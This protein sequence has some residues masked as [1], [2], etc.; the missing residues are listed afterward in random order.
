[1]SEP[2]SVCMV[3]TFYPPH[4]FGGDAMHVYR[5]SNELARRGHDV[6]VVH[7]VAAYRALVGRGPVEGGFPNEP[8]VRVLGI[9]TPLGR[10][11]LLADYL[12]GRPLVG[13]SALRE[14]L[15]RRFDVV[16]FHN[17]S[18]VGGPG[19]LALG[20]RRAVRLYTTNEHWLVC[21]MHVL[22]RMNKEPCTRPTCTRCA[23]AFRRPPQPW[24]WTGALERAT[25]SIDL[26][27]SPSRFT[28]QAHLERGFRRPIVH[29][30]H[31]LPRAEVERSQGHVATVPRPARPYFLYAG[32]L[33]RLKGVQ[34]LIDLFARYDAADLM[35]VG[36]G[37][38]EAELRRRAEG[39]D[40]VRFTGRVSPEELQGL[41]RDAIAL[42]VPS[43][44]YEVFG[45]VVLEAFAQ[46]TPVI[47]HDLGALPELVAET[48]GGWAYRTEG[49]LVEAL[50]HARLDRAERDGRGARG[51]AGWL[52][53]YT[54]EQHVP[55]YL[56]LVRAQRKA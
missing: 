18:L 4:H 46:G 14:I 2:L 20:D 41:Y 33:E 27:L 19:T 3:T 39:C 6:T 17:V 37:A 50:E 10:A 8:G 12:T 26:F 56:E 9:D 29:F 54:E 24:R 42:V 38:H 49:E 44:G 22:W 15:E 32:R 53:G 28:V 1:M 25:A 48:G 16:H 23:L 7:S 35:I 30:P 52:S 13:G 5:L 55:A 51:R 43:V 34:V 47:V 11:G 45:L 40:H 21:P 31:F 36:S